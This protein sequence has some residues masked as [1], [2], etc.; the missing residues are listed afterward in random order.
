M[1]WLTLL[2]QDLTLGEDDLVRQFLALPSSMLL[3]KNNNNNKLAIMNGSKA[4]A[5]IQSSATNGLS[6]KRMKLVAS[7]SYINVA[8]AS[9]YEYILTREDRSN[10]FTSNKEILSRQTTLQSGQLSSAPSAAQS[11]QSAQPTSSHPPSSSGS[12]SSSRYGPISYTGTTWET[13]HFTD[14]PAHV[15]AMTADCRYSHGFKVRS[16]TYLQDKKKMEAGPA[17]GQFLHMDTFAIEK[18]KGTATAAA[19]E[20]YGDRY[21]HVARQ[22]YVQERIKIIRRV[23]KDPITGQSPDVIVINFQ[24]AGDPAIML[25]TYFAI[26]A[27]YHEDIKGSKDLQAAQRLYARFKEGIPFSSLSSSSSSS[28]SSAASLSAGSNEAGSNGSNGSSEQD[29]VATSI[30]SKRVTF[31]DDEKKSVEQLKVIDSQVSPNRQVGPHCPDAITVDT[32][33]KVEEE[34]EEELTQSAPVM[35]ADTKPVAVTAAAAV[36]RQQQPS[37][38][39][40][41][42]IGEA[43]IISRSTSSL[44]V[45]SPTSSSLTSP[46][47]SVAMFPTTIEEDERKDKKKEEKKKKNEEIVSVSPPVAVVTAA[48]PAIT[49]AVAKQEDKEEDEEKDEEPPYWAGITLASLKA[50][51]PEKQWMR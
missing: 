36:G 43:R 2:S 30:A 14:Q 23:L 24:I 7:N 21:D 47:S 16:A 41:V 48:A 9:G 37:S 5:A 19:T 50:H 27:H 13:F 20:I 18:D 39:S 44:H 12:G 33:N 51:Q 26:P 40:E 45:I 4:A 8:E 6:N 49:L 42:V 15:R 22:P 31:H 3:N 17:I 35:L 25:V 32:A 29:Q 10:L 38:R 1:A 11:I 28:S 46:T 34:E